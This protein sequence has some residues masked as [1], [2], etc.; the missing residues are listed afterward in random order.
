MQENNRK[1]CDFCSATAE[2][3]CDLCG[4]DYCTLC[5]SVPD[6]GRF[7]CPD[8]GCPGYG[9]LKPGMRRVA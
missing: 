8:D 9:T 6:E 1:I 7:D 5:A 3:H 4:A 2:R